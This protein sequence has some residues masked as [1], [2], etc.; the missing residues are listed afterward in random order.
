L[1][2]ETAQV[3]G[4]WFQGGPATVRGLDRAQKPYIGLG[5]Q[6]GGLHGGGACVAMADGSVRWVRDS[7]NPLVFES[8]STMAGGESLPT[9]W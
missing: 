2:A 9:N 3:S 5:R 6:F 1:I 4:S 7:I 8:L